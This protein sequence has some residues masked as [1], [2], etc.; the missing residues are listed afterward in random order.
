MQHTL[1]ITSRRTA[2]RARNPRWFRHFTF[3]P[4][5]LALSACTTPD[6][7]ALEEYAPQS[8]DA[9]IE[10]VS[11]SASD[12]DTF[13]PERVGTEFPDTTKQVAVWYRWDK[14]D[15]GKKV[16]IRWS[17][18]GEVVLEQ[19][20]TLA[21]ISGASA[22][23]LKMAAGSKLPI[24]NYQVELLENGVAV[25]KIP[26]KVG[27]AGGSEI[28]AAPADDAGAAESPAAAAEPEAAP[29]PEEGAEEEPSA[30]APAAETATADAAPAEVQPTPAAG[31]A[32]RGLAA[33]ET[34]WPG[35]VVEVTEFARKG[36]ALSAKLRFTN[37]GSKKARPEY[38]YRDTYVLD[39]NN[40]K[41]QVLKDDKGA[42]LGS[43]SSGYTYWWGEDIEP[44]ASRTAWMRFQAPPAGV[45]TMTLQ[46]GTLDPFED[47]QVQ[48]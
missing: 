26:F 1:V 35:V 45:K 30:E 29:P 18:N 34:E 37:N 28:A 6:K 20:D 3:G 36:N 40:K 16:G 43:V 44:G 46:V 8:P 47:V 5:L 17:K 42:F 7:A 41:Y 48:N 24:G 38:Y 19:G 33:Q 13:D 12:D 21:K 14:A 31:R 2:M 22:Y 4:A 11:L 23:V 39:E 9:D 15:S 25:T 10:A 27:D 32:V